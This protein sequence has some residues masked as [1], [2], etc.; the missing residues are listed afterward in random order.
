MGQIFV[1]LKSTDQL[2]HFLNIDFGMD[3]LQHF[4]AQQ[5]QQQV[6]STIIISTKKLQPTKQG[7]WLKDSI[8]N[9]R[10]QLAKASITKKLSPYAS[11]IEFVADVN[12]D[13]FINSIPSNAMAICTG[14][15]Q[16]FKKS[17][18]SKFRHFS[19]VHPSILPYYKG[20][21]PIE[22][23]L[24]N[25]EKYVGWSLHEITE[26]IDAGKIIHQS[27]IP[28]QSQSATDLK[29]KIKEEAKDFLLSYIQHLVSGT[30][31][32]CTLLQAKDYYHQFPDYLS[33]FQ[34]NTD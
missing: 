8:A 10:F 1:F 18:I 14:F 32:N 19:N 12:E 34:S 13:I 22:W 29:N 6:D 20:P 25:S 33:F 4:H 26:Q 11:N 7:A 23:C 16:I 2:Y 3:F 21:T 30:P 5:L 9:F 15:N 27:A 28:V 31:I 24:H 17:L